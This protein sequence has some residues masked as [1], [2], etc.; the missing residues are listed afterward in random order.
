MRII[1][2][3]LKD[4]RQ[5]FRDR[6]SLLFLLIMP[7]AFTFFFGFAFAKPTGEQDTRLKVGVVNH[8][9]NGSLSGALIDLLTASSAVRPVLVDQATAAQLDSQVLKGDLTA[10]LVIPLDYSEAVLKGEMPELEIIIDE[11]SNNGQTMR[12]ALQTN[13]TR[14]FS[15]VEAAELSAR[16]LEA[17]T[18]FT[19]QAE[20]AAYLNDAV[21]RALL[22]WKEQPLSITVTVP[23][24]ESGAPAA[25]NPYNQFSPGMIVQFVIFGLTQAAMVMVIERKTGAMARLLTTPLKKAELIAGH[26]L[27]MFILFFLQQVLL[28][29]FGQFVLKVDYL[30]EPLAILTV[31]TALAL[32]VS[33][34]GL[35]ISALARR[36]DQVILW[37]MIAMFLFSALG[38]S[39][40][41]LE[42]VG[43]AF[44][45]IGHLTPTAWAMDAFQ[46]ILMRGLGLGSVF[47][48][49]SIIL[50]YSA[51]FFG[52]AVWR[53][54]FE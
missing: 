47:L 53:F 38:G 35:L 27:G 24:Q 9:P 30:R 54:K 5:V 22:A 52:L 16:A 48:P 14:L 44:A 6:K 12:R 41:S 50:A 46:N 11:E 39:W 51:A 3:A 19:S 28:V 25:D 34:L 1:D 26:I 13:I 20:R 15:M 17:Q 7:I 43:K 42:M 40:F 45:T 2:L 37:A 10:G 32:F 21:T 23:V 8:D 18:P 4:L 29:L 49:V 31:I 33:T 36:E